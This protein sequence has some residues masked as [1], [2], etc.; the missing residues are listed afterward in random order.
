ML[1]MCRDSGV[2]AIYSGHDHSND[3]V[4]QWNGTRLAY[5]CVQSYLHQLTNFECKCPVVLQ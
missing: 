5:G 2:N 1:M 3:Y 4:A